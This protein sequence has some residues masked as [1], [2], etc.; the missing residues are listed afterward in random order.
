MS[1]PSPLSL[2][3]FSLRL[4]KRARSFWVGTNRNAISAQLTAALL[5]YALSL[6]LVPRITIAARTPTAKTTASKNQVA[7][8]DSINGGVVSHQVGQLSG[9][10]DPLPAT[11]T[12]AVVSRHKPNLNSGLIKGSLRVLKGESFGI[13]GTTQIT[14]DLYLPGTPTIQLSGNARYAGTVSDGGA[15]TPTNYAVSLGG[16]IDLPGHI[17]TNVDPVQL[18]TDFPTSIP[19]ASG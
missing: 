2:L 10:G 19:T 8:N 11:I 18:P 6:Q 4:T 7:E 17:H 1:M 15:T 3:E 16:D 9:G 5:I 12:D 13:N 14:S